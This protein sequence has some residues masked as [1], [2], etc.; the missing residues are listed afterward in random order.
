MS[1]DLQSLRLAVAE[2]AAFRRR[3]RLQPVGGIGE[4]IFPSTY[5]GDE[6]EKARH[7]FEKRR[8]NG[9]DVWTVLLDSVQ[10]SN[11]RG[12]EVLLEL[13]RAG[14][15]TLPYLSVNFAQTEVPE[16][17]EIT[18][19]DAPHRIFDAIFRDSQLDGK[20]LM[21][22]DLG[23]ELQ[24]AKAANA[25]AIF[26]ASPTALLLGAWNSTGEGGGLGAKFA[27]C[28][29]SEIIGVG[30]PVE[31]RAGKEPRSMGRR[32]GSRIDPLGISKHVPVFKGAT[33]VDWV[34]KEQAGY[35]KVRPS[36]INHSNIPPSVDDLGVTM[37]YA[38]HTVVITFAGLRRLRFGG[39]ERDAAA[40]TMLAVLGLVTHLAQAR[41]GY[42][43]RSRCDLV[44][45][46]SA[47]LELV[48][49]DGTI[50]SL[51]VTFDDAVRLYG[52]AVEAARMVGFNIPTEPVRLTP[53]DKLV[54]LVKQSRELALAGKGGEALEV[55]PREV[56]PSV[57]A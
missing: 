39:G 9:E 18:S 42:A 33:A 34:S 17:G 19:L 7:I 21:K 1:L 13:A 4:K 54:Y 45:E 6:R 26:Q 2:H 44:C 5:P 35:K 14:K 25:T 41:Q 27:R 15:I 28:L 47:P 40:R 36:D 31:E 53:Q 10:S 29:V 37:D 32:P 16:I 46:G 48:K 24:L 52:E 38:E 51:D 12:E 8:I 22:S 49:F 3:Q 43:L 20:P 23:R 11:N 57:G 50:H 55:P 30:V 56:T